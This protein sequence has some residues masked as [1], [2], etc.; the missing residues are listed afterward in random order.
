M[1]IGDITISGRLYCESPRLPPYLLR[2]AGL[3]ISTVSRQISASCLFRFFSL[4]SRR[5]RVIV[6]QHEL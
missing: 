5:A 3:T 6:D 4:T 2:A 1:P